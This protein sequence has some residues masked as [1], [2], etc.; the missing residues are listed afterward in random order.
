MRNSM[1]KLESLYTEWAKSVRLFA[2]PKNQQ[3][4]MT[5]SFYSGVMTMFR[6]VNDIAFEMDQ[7]TAIKALDDFDIEIKQK[8]NFIMEELHLL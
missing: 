6:L 4:M 2:K 3:V 1:T 8:M 5:M 7:D